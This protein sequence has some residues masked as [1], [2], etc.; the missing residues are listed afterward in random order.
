ME[1]IS[2]ESEDYK[3]MMERPWWQRAIYNIWPKIYRVLN[4]V[5]FFIF[6]IL[7][8]TVKMAIKQIKRN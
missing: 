5:L 7:K 1:K 8:T 3:N 2:R 4:E 6:M